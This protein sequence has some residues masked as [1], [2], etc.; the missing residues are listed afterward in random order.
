MC[1][2]FT[3]H[4]SIGINTFTSEKKMRTNQNILSI[5]ALF[6]HQDKCVTFPKK[7]FL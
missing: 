1:I 5:I 4:T 6:M 3:K 7:H 2:A